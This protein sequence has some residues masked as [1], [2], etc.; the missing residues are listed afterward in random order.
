MGQ[1]NVRKKEVPSGIISIMAKIS[2]TY[3]IIKKGHYIIT[4]I[5]KST[6]KEIGDVH[7]VSENETHTEIS[8]NILFDHDDWPMVKSIGDIAFEV[9]NADDDFIIFNGK[10]VTILF[11]KKIIE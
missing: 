7:I 8:C 11:T 4:A 6:K 2:F 9:Y 10:D 5:E 1:A 3:P